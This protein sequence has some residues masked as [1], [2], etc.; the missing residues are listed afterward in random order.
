VQS[1]YVVPQ[2]YTVTSGATRL[3]LVYP[4][5]WHA[6]VVH[7][8]ALLASPTTTPPLYVNATPPG[9]KFTVRF[10]CVVAVCAL[11]P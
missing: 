4:A 9:R 11:V 10:A 3:P 7:V 2:L 8:P 1:A 5:L 6:F